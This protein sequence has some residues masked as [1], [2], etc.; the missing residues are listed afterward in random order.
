ML[1]M[2]SALSHCPHVNSQFFVS[3]NALGEAEAKPKR[4]T[5]MQS[6]LRAKFFIFF[7]YIK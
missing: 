3:R 6:N 5:A 2:L 4:Q 1:H 7:F